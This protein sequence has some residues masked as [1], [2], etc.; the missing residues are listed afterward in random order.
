MPNVRSTDLWERLGDCIYDYSKEKIQQRPSVHGA[1]NI[2]TDLSGENALISGDFYYLGRNAIK[3][4]KH[5]AGIC[6]Q[7]QGH[8]SDSNAPYV[9]SFVDWLRNLSLEPGRMHGWP[10]FMVEWQKIA[11]GDG[12][13]ARKRDGEHDPAC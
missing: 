13:P 2:E 6:H 1:T 12:C 9:D 8:R 10:D 4:P 11:S 5:L 3:L 7:T